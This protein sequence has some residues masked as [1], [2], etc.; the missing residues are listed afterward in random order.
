MLLIERYAPQLYKLLSFR[1]NI[2]L[3]STKYHFAFPVVGV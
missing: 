1:A 2:S 3:M